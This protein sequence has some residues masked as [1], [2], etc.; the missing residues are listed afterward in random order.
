MTMKKTDNKRIQ[1]ITGS[2]GGCGKS[3]LFFLLAEKY[4]EAVVLDMDDATQTTIQSLA[5]RNPK[6]VSFLNENKAIDR[7]LL[8]DFF[9]HIHLHKNNHFLCDMGASIAEQLPQYM[10]DISAAEFAS[11]LQQIGIEVE[12]VCVVGG[13]DIFKSTMMYLAD[14][15]EAI[16]GHIKIVVAYNE[17]FLLAPEQKEQLKVF[18]EAHQLKLI[19]FNISSDRNVSTQNRIKEVLKSGKGCDVASIFSK[20]YFIN[21]IE[22]LEL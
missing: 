15:T 13:A 9:E 3:T 8:N 22:K 21:A 11:L 17:Y 12:L 16:E 5:Y 7:G 14:L 20:M 4:K 19:S 2:K 18:V 10:R 1:M 6:L